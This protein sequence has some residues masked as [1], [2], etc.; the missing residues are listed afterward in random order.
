MTIATT[1]IPRTVPTVSAPARPS[2]V[3]ALPTLAAG[4][5]ALSVRSPRAVAAPL[6][7]PILFA[8]VVAPALADGVP[9]PAQRPYYMTFFCMATCGLLVPLNCMFFGLGVLVDRQQGAMRELLVA[10]IRRSSIVFGN[11]AAAAVITALQLAFPLMASVFRGAQ[12][13]MSSRLFWFVAAA[14]LL[15]AV[16]YG[17]AEM[18]VTR[19]TSAEEYSGVIPA[20]AIVPFLSP[21]PCT[22]SPRCRPGWPMWPRYCH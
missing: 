15:I 4:R 6:M 11:L 1:A 8:R 9:S 5:L 20:V 14:L 17:I 21:V 10:P 7:A 2:R 3:R 18:L 19:L 12:Y 13:D 22:R 16:I